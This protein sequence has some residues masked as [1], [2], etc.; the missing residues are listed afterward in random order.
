MVKISL[1][2]QEESFLPM[3]LQKKIYF[4]SLV[5]ILLL[6]KCRAHVQDIQFVAGDYAG[7]YISIDRGYV[8]AGLFAPVL[9]SN[10]YTPFFDVRAYRFNDDRWAASAGFGIRRQLSEV[11]ALGINAYYDYRRG[12]AKHNFHQIG[13]GLE[14]LSCFDLRVNGYLPI[15]RKTQLSEFCVFDQLG[16]GFFATRS[17]N[18]FSYSGFDAEVGKSLWHCRDLNLYGAAGPY[19]YRSSHHK[20]FWGGYGRLGLIWRSFLSLQIRTSYDYLHSAKVQG[21]F[22]IFFPL[23]VFCKGWES[24]G[25]RFIDQQVWRNRIILTD[26]CCNWTWNWDDIN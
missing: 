26:H 17:R 2:Y 16:D 25:C 10:C 3:F 22:Q 5:A 18:E 12:E 7:K 24:C 1:A 11:S 19:Y 21:I 8:E 6:G 15:L 23:E 13:V 4:L 20:R 14:W 9:L